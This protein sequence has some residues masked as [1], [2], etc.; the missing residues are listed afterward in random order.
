MLITES[1]GSC[2]LGHLT[3]VRNGVTVAAIRRVLAG[4]DVPAVVTAITTQ[5]E[6]QAAKA[7]AEAGFTRRAKSVRNPR[8]G[9]TVTLWH[10]AKA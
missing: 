5:R 4:R 3:G 6:K 8:S 1:D 9:N 10:Y 2:A 7:L